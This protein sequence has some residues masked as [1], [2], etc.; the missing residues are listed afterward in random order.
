[1]ELSDKDVNKV[2]EKWAEP[3]DDDL[4]WATIPLVDDRITEL[5]FGD[6]KTSTRC[7]WTYYIDKYYGR[8]KSVD[9]VLSLCCGHGHLERLI[10]QILKIRRLDALDISKQALENARRLAKKAGISNIN[11]E[12]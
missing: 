12:C 4:K 10:T 2:S 9:R 6:S 7:P 11:Y 3:P 1:M 5:I 8:Q